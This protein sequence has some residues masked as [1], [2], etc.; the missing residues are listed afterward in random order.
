MQIKAEI[1][2]IIKSDITMTIFN[3]RCMKMIGEFEKDG[4]YALILLS[5]V[6][7]NGLWLGLYRRS[8]PVSLAN[9]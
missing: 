2:L 6:V 5:I 8:L 4:L 1:R 3:T 9:L 7:R